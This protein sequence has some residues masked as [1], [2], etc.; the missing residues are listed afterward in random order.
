ME[1]GTLPRA[2]LEWVLRSASRAVP[3]DAM[4]PG[5][6]LLTHLL[7]RFTPS[8]AWGGVVPVVRVR[9][10]EPDQRRGD[11]DAPAVRVLVSWASRSGTTVLTRYDALM[12]RLQ[13]GL[14]R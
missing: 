7:A 14:R 10:R 6:M 1:R 11:V 4:A 3:V 9:P 12:T 2:A 13:A 8:M 5:R